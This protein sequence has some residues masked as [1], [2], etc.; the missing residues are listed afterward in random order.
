MTDKIE[1]GGIKDSSLT[2]AIVIFDLV[3]ERTTYHPV[4]SLPG[5][6]P[7]LPKQGRKNCQ[8][9]KRAVRITAFFSHKMEATNIISLLRGDNHPIFSN[10]E[11][12]L[13]MAKFLLPCDS[14]LLSRLETRQ[15]FEDV[16][17]RSLWPA[18]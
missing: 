18:V 5:C 3:S 4:V 13:S 1:L 2:K 15:T 9:Q 11:K 16:A 17:H 10:E 8:D 12:E 14:K 6:L 7:P